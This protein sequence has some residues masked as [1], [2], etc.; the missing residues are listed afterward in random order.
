MNLN[1]FHSISLSSPGISPWKGDKGRGELIPEELVYGSPAVNSNVGFNWTNNCRIER[2]SVAEEGNGKWDSVWD[3]FC[4]NLN[5]NY[6]LI[7][8]LLEIQKWKIEFK[9]W[10]A[11][12][13]EDFWNSVLRSFLVRQLTAHLT[14]QPSV[15]WW[16]YSSPSC[17]CILFTSDFCK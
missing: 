7:L 14:P 12:S 13:S 3:P 8:I 15:H 17:Y 1:C 6:I 16:M 11:I 4:L 2:P 5:Y 10:I 9:W